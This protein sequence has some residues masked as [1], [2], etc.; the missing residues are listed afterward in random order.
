PCEV[1]DPPTPSGARGNDLLQVGHHTDAVVGRICAWRVEV[2]IA[3]HGT[4]AGWRVAL[5]VLDEPGLHDKRGAGNDG[6]STSSSTK[7]C[8]VRVSGVARPAVAGCVDAVAPTVAI[9][10]AAV[11]GKA[12]ARMRRGGVGGADHDGAG[13][14]KVVAVAVKDKLA[15]GILV[16][17]EIVRA[18]A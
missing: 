18:I 11:V 9:D 6:T 10:A 13:I 15:V 14:P 16:A 1:V 7:G 5:A 8:R 3:E 17:V 2:G 4:H 12:G